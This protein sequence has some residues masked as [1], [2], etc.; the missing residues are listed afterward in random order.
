MQRR[1]HGRVNAVDRLVDGL[2]ADDHVVL[3]VAH[4]DDETI[5]CGAH[6]SRWAAALTIVHVTDGSPSDDGDAKAAGCA[7]ANDY[8]A[9]RQ[10]ELVCAMQVARVEPAQL[11]GL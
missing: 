3:V 9:L 11:I 7:S 2:A 6:L 8:A 5:G 10:R 1:R 4:P